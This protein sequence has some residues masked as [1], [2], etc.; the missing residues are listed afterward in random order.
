M[1]GSAFVP[2]LLAVGAFVLSMLVLF[3]GH[4][5]G[6]LQDVYVIKIDTARLGEGVTDIDRIT[7]RFG[8]DDTPT[9]VDVLDDFLNDVKN[10]TEDKLEDL[11]DTA[12]HSIGLKDVYVAHIM[13]YCTGVVTGDEN[14]N[15][16]Y[17][18]DCSKRKVP[19]AFDPISILQQDILNGV[20]L[21]DVGFP[22]ETVEDVVGALQVAYKTM[23]MCYVLG[24][25][26][27]G[28]AILFGVFGL[29]G[30]RMVELCTGLVAF[31]GFLLLGIASAIGTAI[32]I[33]I[34]DVIN[35]HA[36]DAGV[37]ASDSKK[38]LGMTWGAVAAMLIASVIW[39]LLCC[40]GGDK[41]KR[42]S[43]RSRHSHHDDGPLVHE[44][45]HTRRRFGFF[46]RRRARV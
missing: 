34:R 3:S 38:Y 31:M 33:K 2:L 8:I 36:N 17:I 20:T 19:F 6:F 12:A 5:R 35:K 37:Y 10:K 9:N 43:R 30:A 16:T 40:F 13:T 26:F 27:T 14:D 7:D 4:T 15:S 23:S 22:T 21:D 41:S 28:L 44:K 18:T 25:A 42:R 46:G 1:R 11:I 45:V 24:I 39:S 32:A 29:T